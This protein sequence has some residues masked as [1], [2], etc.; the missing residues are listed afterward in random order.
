MPQSLA[1]DSSGLAD[2][3]VKRLQ[4]SMK[5][6]GGMRVPV[7]STGVTSNDA[8]KLTGNTLKSESQAGPEWLVPRAQ[9]HVDIIVRTAVVIYHE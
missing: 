8:P 5:F 1:D 9:I 4:H 7:I 2:L 3:V 6:F